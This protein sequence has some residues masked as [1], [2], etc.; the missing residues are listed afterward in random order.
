MNVDVSAPAVGPRSAP[1]R[2]APKAWNITLWVVQGLLAVM[3][4]I[5]G[6]MK[7]TMPI[8]ELTEK[9]V[10][11]GA[12]PSALV[13]FIGLSEL[14]AA[15]GLIAPAA[16]RI[17]PVLTP[18]AGVGLVIVM[19]FAAIF[20]ITRGELG[21]LPTNLVLGALAAFVAWGRFRKA[22]IPPR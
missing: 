4:G 12:A 9:M 15:I 11:P 1:P 18:L 8:A 6:F 2:S 13:R 16:T 3:F 19:L 17:K 21:A 14:A 5:A 7:L 20:H 10:W 22:P